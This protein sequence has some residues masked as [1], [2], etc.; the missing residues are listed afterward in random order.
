MQPAIFL[1]GGLL[2]FVCVRTGYGALADPS[3]Y[4]ST[5]EIANLVAVGSFHFL[6]DALAFRP[7]VI[8]PPRHR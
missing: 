1:T 3:L 6:V 5:V 8:H 7:T 4:S 2:A